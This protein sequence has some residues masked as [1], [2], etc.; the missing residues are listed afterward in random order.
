MSPKYRVLIADDH[1]IVLD[2]VRS[3][4]ESDKRFEVVADAANGHEVIA[5]VEAQQPDVVVLDLS[6]PDADG[7]AVIRTIKRRFPDI[8]VVIQSVHKSPQ[9]L[10]DCLLAGVTGYVVKGDP[11]ANLLT[12]ISSV[13]DGKCFLSPSACAS[14]I[15]RYLQLARSMPTEQHFAESLTERERD[16][17]RYTA[18]G[19]TAKEI[20]RRLDLSPK[21]VNNHLHRLKKKLNVDKKSALIRYAVEN[22][23]VEQVE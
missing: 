14:L 16:I 19:L 10:H 7:T 8:S 6:M 13:A 5:Q 20:A 17:L 9:I 22:D 3:L 2:G 21:T 23:L 15:D 11:N 12:A 1:Q 18:Q 4:L